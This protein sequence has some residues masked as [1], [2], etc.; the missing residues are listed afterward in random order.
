MYQIQAT[1]DIYSEYS[2]Y[3]KFVLPRDDVII[4]KYYNFLLAVGMD[5]MFSTNMR[6]Q[7]I[8]KR[9]VHILTILSKFEFSWIENFE[10]FQNSV[11]TFKIRIWWMS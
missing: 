4:P 5:A 10:N 8:T 9:F 2:T 7:T 6:V 1:I 3:W 11:A